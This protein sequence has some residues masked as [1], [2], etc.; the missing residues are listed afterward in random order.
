HGALFTAA[1]ALPPEADTR[2]GEALSRAFAQ[3]AARPRR[4]SFFKQDAPWPGH[5]WAARALSDVA[6]AEAALFTA[7]RA[8]DPELAGSALNLLAPRSGSGMARGGLGALG[9]A[10]AAC[11]TAAGAELRLGA[12]VSEVR[13]G[14]S[15][16]TGLLLGDGSEIAASAIISTLDLRRSFLSLFKWSALPQ[17]LIVRIGAFRMTGSTARLLLALEKPPRLDAAPLILDPA[18]AAS[19]AAWR[20][21]AI[22]EQP[23]L[24]LRLVTTSDPALAPPGAGIV[25]VTLGCI[26]HRLFDGPWT[27]GKRDLLRSRVLAMMEPTLGALRPLA[28]KL[29]VPPDIEETLGLTDGDLDGGE[30]APDQMLNFRPGPRTPLAGFYLAGPSSMAGPLATCAGGWVAARALLADRA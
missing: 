2:R 22:P 30:I 7:G 5:D 26:P 11:A 8:I 1:R 19:L 25:T 4:F 29:I 18:P 27:E 3:A 6:G 24:M 15:R 16:V 13:Q 23:P 28:A 10:L 14:K 17:P 21:A 12:E 20:D 9:G